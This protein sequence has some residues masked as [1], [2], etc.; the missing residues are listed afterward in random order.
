MNKFFT[1]LLI[2][3]LAASCQGAGADSSPL[4][5]RIDSLEKKLAHT[6]KPGLGEFMSGIQV[7]HAKLWFAGVNGNWPLADFEVH[8]IMESIDDIKAFNTDRAEIKQLPM[9]QGPLDSINVAIQQKSDTRFKA[10]FRLLT[11]TCNNCHQIT[12]H[13]FNVIKIPDTPPFTNQDFGKAK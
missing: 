11:S 9:I 8:E 5:S 7:H 3:I 2:A 1:A 12:S 6:Y 4:Q 13:G 10:A